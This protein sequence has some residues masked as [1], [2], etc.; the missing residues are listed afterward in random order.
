MWRLEAF[1]LVNHQFRCASLIESKFGSP[2]LLGMRRG[3][4]VESVR[5][6]LDLLPVPDLVQRGRHWPRVMR[7]GRREVRLHHCRR[8]ALSSS[9]ALGGAVLLGN[10]DERLRVV[11]DLVRRCVS[12]RERRCILTLPRLWQALV[13]LSGAHLAKC[14]LR[15]G[16]FQ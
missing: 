1:A 5:G 9:E 4:P 6:C 16:L 10:L 12:V 15:H 2:A 14:V 11:I 7:C 13:K 8:L 3:H